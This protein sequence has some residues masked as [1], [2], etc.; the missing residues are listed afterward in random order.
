MIDVEA[1]CA[2][3]GYGGPRTATLDTLRAIHLLHPQAIAFETLDVLLRRPVRLDTD[4]LQRKL[5]QAGRGGELPGRAEVATGA[6][7][8]PKTTNED[9]ARFI[10]NSQDRPTGPSFF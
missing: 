5:V 8:A 2:R 4:N 6:M 1:Y 3:I 7:T 9:S 10:G